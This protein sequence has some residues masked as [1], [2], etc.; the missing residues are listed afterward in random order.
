MTIRRELHRER[1]GDLHHLLLGDGEIADQ[2]HRIGVEA[3]AG[4]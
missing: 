1:A 2:R 3:D 4:A